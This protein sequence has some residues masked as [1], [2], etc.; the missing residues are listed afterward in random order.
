[1]PI[2][3]RK[4]RDADAP[5]GLAAAILRDNVSPLVLDDAAK[6]LASGPLRLLVVDD[7]DRGG[8]QAVEMLSM[9]AVRCAATRVAVIATAGGPLGL[10]PELRLGG[11]S[12][13]DLAVAI[14]GLAPEVN[15]ALWL[16][17]Q[18]LPGVAR[19]LAQELT[20]LGD[21]DDPVVHLALIAPSRAAFLDADASEW[22]LTQD[23]ADWLLTAGDEEARLRDGRGMHYLR[24]LLAAP[25]QELRALDLAAGGAGLVSPP[26]G[27][28]IDTAARDAYR[29]RLGAVTAALE[30]ADRA[31]DEEAAERA[32]IE[33]QALLHQLRGATG[34]GGR[35]RQA[36]PE[37]ERASQRHPD[38]ARGDRQD[39]RG[40]PARRRPGTSQGALRGVAVR[41]DH[42]GE[43]PGGVL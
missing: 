37:A 41:R 35:S 24:A 25:G 8:P 31:G 6:H 17:S 10:R 42:G 1:V 3:R 27:P 30:A 39:R 12:Q 29:R 15:H 21:R 38:P 33:R 16:A 28:V 4:V 13:A 34:L 22:T 20:G 7:I 11:L 36:A 40:R 18:G 43:R 14:G 9:V 32:E 23:G 26:P 2:R 5:P 19:E